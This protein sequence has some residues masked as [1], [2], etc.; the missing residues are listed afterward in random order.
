M[1]KRERKCRKTAE[2]G[3]LN[4]EIKNTIDTTTDKG[5]QYDECAKRI[6]GQKIIECVVKPLASAMGI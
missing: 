5:A 6:L 2:G 1:E 3:L 4:Q